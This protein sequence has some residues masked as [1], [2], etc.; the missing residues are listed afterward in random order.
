MMSRDAESPGGGRETASQA[1]SAT[2]Q[3]S[4]LLDALNA[5]TTIPR[6]LTLAPGDAPGQSG[7]PADHR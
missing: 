2:Q 3:L 6:R 1:A 5:G 7:G 4:D